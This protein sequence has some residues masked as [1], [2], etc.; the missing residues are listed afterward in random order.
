MKDVEQCLFVTYE[1]DGVYQIQ[2]SGL[3][4][5]PGHVY[6]TLVVGEQVSMLI[7]NGFGDDIF[8]PFLSLLTDR[9]SVV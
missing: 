4:P 3:V 5:G 8:E 9:K 6:C 1:K 2:C 7:D